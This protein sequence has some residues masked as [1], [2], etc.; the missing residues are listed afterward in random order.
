VI[1]SVFVSSHI[2]IN[3]ISKI[4]NTQELLSILNLFSIQNLFSI[5]IIPQH[6]QKS[7]SVVE[8]F[9]FLLSQNVLPKGKYNKIFKDSIR[10]YQSKQP[11][12]LNELEKKYPYSRERIRQIRIRFFHETEKTLLAL[13]NF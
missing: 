12:S 1:L 7:R 4:H 9:Y 13:K 5:N 11:L 3:K 6:I 8:I 10:I 2:F